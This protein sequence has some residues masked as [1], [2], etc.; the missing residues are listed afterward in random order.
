MGQKQP[1]IRISNS[2]S[3]AEVDELLHAVD[4]RARDHA[5]GEGEP[6][7]AFQDV[8]GKVNGM[9]MQLRRKRIAA[10]RGC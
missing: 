5:R 8:V 7:K 3:P 2:F 10:S 4:S 1:A 9:K 6:P